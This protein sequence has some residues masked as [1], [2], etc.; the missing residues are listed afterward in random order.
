M[1]NSADYG[2]M[3]WNGESKGTFNNIMNLLNENKKVLI[4][5][6]PTN[7]LICIDCFNKLDAL[8]SSCSDDV[9]KLFKKL[10][11]KPTHAQKQLTLSMVQAT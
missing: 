9:K 3:L 6:S 1:A 4:F 5:F 2:F 11:R 8:L 10:H 7:K